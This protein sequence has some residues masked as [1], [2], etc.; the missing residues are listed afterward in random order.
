MF[1]LALLFVA[2]AIALPCHS[3]FLH[4]DAAETPRG[5]GAV[6]AGA[7]VLA[8]PR[9]GAINDDRLDLDLDPMPVAEVRAGYAIT[10]SLRVDGALGFIRYG[11]GLLEPLAQAGMRYVVARPAG[12]G[13]AP[14]VDFTM[15]ERNIWLATAGLAVEGGGERIRFDIAL[16]PVGI[17]DQGS[18]SGSSDLYLPPLS[19]L[20]GELGIT[21]QVTERHGLRLGTVSIAP[22][23]TWDWAGEGWFADAMFAM[24]PSRTSLLLLSAH[25]G[26]RF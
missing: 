1:S 6:G 24:L 21:W 17:M 11:E 4:P 22:S 19:L 10:D 5:E 9:L 20:F 8:T 2:P 25:F 3:G 26:R 16:S 13:F 14:Y 18:R 12:I 7:G 23:L 15:V